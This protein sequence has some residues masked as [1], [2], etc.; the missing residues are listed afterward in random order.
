[1]RDKK[2]YKI[3]FGKHQFSDA[4]NEWTFV[5]VP[6]LLDLSLLV[7]FSWKKC[8]TFSTALYG[9]KLT[10][11]LSKKCRINRWKSGALVYGK[12]YSLWSGYSSEYDQ[13]EAWYWRIPCYGYCL[14]H[15]SRHI[16][17]SPLCHHCVTC[18]HNVTEMPTT[19]SPINYRSPRHFW[20]HLKNFILTLKWTWFLVSSHNKLP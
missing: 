17:L 2:K 4:W 15:V 1:M 14:L 19:P 9:K 18:R 6:V 20:R 12:F 11:I 7:R 13:K 8:P 10:Q 3:W 16:T 5:A